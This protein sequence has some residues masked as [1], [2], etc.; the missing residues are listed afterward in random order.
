MPTKLVR[1]IKTCTKRGMVKGSSDTVPIQ[2]GLK[3]TDTF[4]SLPL[5]IKF[6]I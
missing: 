1:L 6:R 3:Q 5:P 2:N 4:S